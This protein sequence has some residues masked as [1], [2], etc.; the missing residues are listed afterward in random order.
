MTGDRHAGGT[1][2]AE[3]RWHTRKARAYGVLCS[4]EP[5]EPQQAETCLS[6][7]HYL[8]PDWTHLRHAAW[9]SIP[10]YTY[11]NIFSPESYS[12]AGT[13]ILFIAEERRK[14]MSCP[15]LRPVTFSVNHAGIC[16]QL[17]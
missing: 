4:S 1:I 15:S 5:K 17:V 16:L 3:G 6:A 12:C 10:I 11:S 7:C 13:T 8:M 9:Y 14:T 2:G